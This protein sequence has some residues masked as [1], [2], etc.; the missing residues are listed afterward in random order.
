MF[1]AVNTLMESQQAP[2]PYLEALQ[3]DTHKV[4]A[5]LSSG[6]SVHIRQWSKKSNVNKSLD[7]GLVIPDSATAIVLM[8]HGLG[9]CGLGKTPLVLPMM[10]QG[11]YPIAIE[12]SEIGEN[13]TMRG[14]IDTGDVLL[15]RVQ[16]TVQ[17]LR[18][19]YPS[20]PLFLLGLSLG[21]LLSTIVASKLQ[22]EVSGL[23][24]LSP[25]FG[26]SPQAF[27]PTFVAKVLAQY[28]LEKLSLRQPTW[29]R[30]PYYDNRELITRELGAL[31]SLLGQTPCVKYLNAHSF[32]ELLKLTQFRLPNA[33]SQVYCPTFL[34]MGMQ[35]KV[36]SPKAMLQGFQKFP[37]T[38]KQL[39]QF[40]EA[41]HDIIFEP[42][43]VELSYTVATWLHEQASSI[44]GV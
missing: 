10:E 11:I 12:Q 39:V 5:S 21:G 38:Q 43:G 22:S 26:A 9:G 8:V 32:V 41:Y 29:Q 14:H 33:L 35:D 1:S 42:E 4:K 25:A 7:S 2:N 18:K 23:V 6:E 24:L 17:W 27:P 3:L 15:Q 34:A 19:A 20:K 30:L 28:G 31:D 16:S 36:C 13:T 44:T 40:P 37:S